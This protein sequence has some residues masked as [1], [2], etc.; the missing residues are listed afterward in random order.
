[1]A[2]LTTNFSLNK[3]AVNDAVDQDL[4]GTQLNTN[5]DTIDSALLTARDYP[6][7]SITSTDSLVAGDRNKTLLFTSTGDYTFSLLSATQAGDGFSVTLVKND[8]TNYN[9]ITIDGS[10]NQTIGTAT[11]YTLD[12]PGDS[13]IISSKGTTAGWNIRSERKVVVTSAVAYGCI[14]SNDAGDTDHDINMTAGQRVSTSGRILTLSSERTKK[15]DSTWAAGDDQGGRFTSGFSASQSYH[16]F[17]IQSDADNSVDW[18]YSTDTNCGDIPSG[19][20]NY[21]YVHSLKVAA[22]TVLNGIV[23][24]GE[25][26]MYKAPPLDVSVTSTTSATN[27]TMSIPTGFQFMGLFNAVDGGVQGTIFSSPDVTDAAPSTG[28][29]PLYTLADGGNF[30]ASQFHCLTSSGQIRSRSDNTINLNV[31]TLGYQRLDK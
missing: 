2:T 7:R 3:P 13:V 8:S 11:T 30:H 22:S 17:L 21:A 5:M 26:I 23:N 4:W 12:S 19:Y 1:M 15:A 25:W 28:S 31:V 14:L 16:L 29:S 18:G 10:S 24:A 9:T 6:I 20:T 27:R